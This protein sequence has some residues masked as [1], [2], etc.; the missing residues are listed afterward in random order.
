MVE[1]GST[2]AGIQAGMG[3]YIAAGS[4][5]SLA[6]S[7]AMGGAAAVALGTVGTVLA[8]GAGVGGVGLVT[9]KVLGVLC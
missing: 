9:V 3:G 6:Q 7:M 4:A 1:I 5:F 2:A 8:V